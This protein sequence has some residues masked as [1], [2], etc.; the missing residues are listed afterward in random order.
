LILTIGMV[1]SAI[2]YGCIDYMILHSK[3]SG[4]TQLEKKLKEQNNE[5]VMQRKQ[6][7]KFASKI[8]DLNE[9]ILAL[10]KIEER[11]RDLASIDQ[12]GNAEG[13]FGVGGSAPEGLDP[14]VEL[15]QS[16]HQ[17]IRDMHRKIELL[18]DVAYNQH[19]TFANLLDKLEEQKNLM[20]HMPAI[21]PAQGWV[22]STFS[23]RQSPF[24]SKREFHKGIDIA[25]RHG[26]LIVATADGVV[27][28]SGKQ[29]SFGQM[30]V[31]DHGH[32]VTTRYAH[33]KEGLKKR[34]E[35]VRRGDSI[36]LMGNTGRSTGPHVHYE[37]RMN[38]VP[39]NPEKY[40]LN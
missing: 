1:L 9:R 28:F 18:D 27:S 2:T 10:N 8:N 17:L 31:I 13:V 20:A 34:G 7:Q 36:A 14:H 32:G 5:V 11:V 3:A 4:K 30:L 22:T 12:T 15:T 37:V 39:V 23:Y 21:R 6:I 26:T 24:T 29:G 35:R 33:V 25:N 38:G 19:T 16:H 40:I